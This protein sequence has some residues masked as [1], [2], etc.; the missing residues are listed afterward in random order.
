VI[1]GPLVTRAM[2]V[3]CLIV[4]SADQSC[5]ATDKASGNDAEVTGLA[6]ICSGVAEGSAF[7]SRRFASS[8]PQT[9]QEKL[10]VLR[11]SVRNDARY[12]DRRDLSQ[13]PND[14]PRF[15]KPTHM[16]ITG[17]EE[18]VSH[19]KRG[20]RSSAA[21]RIAAASSNRRLKK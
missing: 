17:R 2:S 10:A 6:P 4:H 18:A 11:F 1:E 5:R 16:R 9:R 12:H 14:L 19:S 8:Q 13:S 15:V 7:G 20:A 21:I 3:A